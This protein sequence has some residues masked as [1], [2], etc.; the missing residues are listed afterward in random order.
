MA[1]SFVVYFLYP[2]DGQS[3]FD[4]D[5]YQSKHI[6]RTNEIWGRFGVKMRSVARLD[7]SYHLVGMLVSYSSL[8]AIPKQPLSNSGQEWANKEDYQS[9]QKYERT[10]ELLDDIGNFTTSKPIFLEGTMLEA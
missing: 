9:A 5:Y 6:P 3:T 1:P 2:R 10:K 8:A 4:Y 7:E